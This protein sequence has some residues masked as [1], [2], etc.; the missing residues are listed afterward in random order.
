MGAELSTNAINF[1][2]EKVYAH[3]ATLMKDGS[4]QVSTVWI[5]R[6]GDSILVNTATGRI[7]EKNIDRDPRV[8]I[9]IF[10]TQNPYQQV[11]IKGKVTDKIF[12]GAKDHINELSRKYTGKNYPSDL[13]ETDTRIIFKITPEKLTYF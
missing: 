6:D 11:L 5:G 12:T 13:L 10:D 3:I 1:L 4:P 9:S 2:R 8:A 7:K